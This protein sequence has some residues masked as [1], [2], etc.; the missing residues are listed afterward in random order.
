M[1]V[2]F[3]TNLPICDFSDKHNHFVS[4]MILINAYVVLDKTLY[5]GISIYH[6]TLKSLKIAFLW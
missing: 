6:M 2:F 3:D 1:L 5:H 4:L